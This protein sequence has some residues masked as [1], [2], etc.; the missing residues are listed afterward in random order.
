MIELELKKIISLIK[1][2]Y[3]EQV[4]ISL[5]VKGLYQLN[6]RGKIIKRNYINPKY[7]ILD[8]KEKGLIKI[9]L[10]DIVD[11]SII[12]ISYE[13]KENKNNRINLP[14]NLRHKILKRDRYTCQSCGA[15]APDVELE[16]D[17]RI[18]VSKGGTDDES[19]LVTLCFDCN[20]GKG[21]R[22]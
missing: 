13:K 12:P 7:I 5:K 9:F 20:R 17:H 1:F 3:R 10:E 4:V 18:P 16:V 8:G 6:I 19:N 21:N 2:Y 14:K 15:R 22:V 11:G